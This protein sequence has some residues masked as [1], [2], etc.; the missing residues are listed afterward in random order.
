MP[1]TGYIVCD[2]KARAHTYGGQAVWGFT[3]LFW[4]TRAGMIENV[5]GFPFKL[6]NLNKLVINVRFTQSYGNG[7][8]KL[9][10]NIFTY[11]KDTPDPDWGIPE[12][13]E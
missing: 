13:R 9:G 11:N 2:T 3:H 4:G 6:E 5:K 8:Y 1:S 7:G 12:K 10:M